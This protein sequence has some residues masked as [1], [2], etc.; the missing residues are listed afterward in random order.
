MP[1]SLEE[2]KTIRL[3]F[4]ITNIT[5][6]RNKSNFKNTEL[7]Y[8]HLHTLINPP[9]LTKSQKKRI[10]NKQRILRKNNKV[11][12][13]IIDDGQSPNSSGGIEDKLIIVD[14]LIINV[15]IENEIITNDGQSPNS[16]GGTDDGGTDDNE[17]IEEIIHKRPFIQFN[18]TIPNIERYTIIN[19]MNLL[20]NN[21][22]DYYNF[23]KINDYH[24]IKIFK[25][26]HLDMSKNLNSYH[27][28]GIFKSSIKESNMF[29]LYIKDNQVVSMTE[30]ISYNFNK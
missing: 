22:V 30:L 1:L 14:G 3:H 17:E 15:P 8:E 4:K 10:K 24:K 5:Q 12:E 19:M 6:S 27:F 25:G 28:N 26:I 16:S 29:H 11:L 9:T 7:F 13:D 21:S 23:I 18:E 2:K 20:W